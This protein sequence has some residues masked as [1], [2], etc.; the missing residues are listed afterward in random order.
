ME[1]L[2]L[3]KIVMCL[4]AVSCLILVVTLARQGWQELSSHNSAQRIYASQSGM[5]SLNASRRYTPPTP[6]EFRSCKK[7]VDEIA[8]AYSNC[9]YEV[10]L[11]LTENFPRTA[12]DLRGDDYIR[13]IL[14][15]NQIWSE[16]WRQNENTKEFPSIDGFR[17]R[18]LTYRT[19][20]ET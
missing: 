12:Y 18:M 15:I 11:Q 1:S 17:R 13:L 3:K 19:L 16:E 14:P 10:I 7:V 9:Q 8:S 2:V 6:E 4:S 5:S 20:A